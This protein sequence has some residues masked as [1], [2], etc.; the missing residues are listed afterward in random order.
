MLQSGFRTEANLNPENEDHCGGVGDGG[1]PI[2]NET[3]LEVVLR[4]WVDFVSHGSYLGYCHRFTNRDGIKRWGL[5]RVE[6]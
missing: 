3:K 1:K 6:R 4:G 5:G 2:L